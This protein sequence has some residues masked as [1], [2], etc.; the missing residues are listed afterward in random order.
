[1]GPTTEVTRRGVRWSL[2]LRE[3]IDFAIWL[4]GAFEPETVRCYE[5]LIKSGDIVLD[6]GANIGAHTLRLAKAV[7]DSGRVIAFEPT[8]YAFAKLRRNCTLNAELSSRI[9]CMQVMLVSSEIEGQPTPSLYSSWPLKG[10]AD[11]HRLHQ[12]RL[13][14]TDGAAARTL[15]SIIMPMGLQR[16]DYMKL[17]IDGHECKMLRG[18]HRVLA[19]WHPTI[20][21]ELMPYG[22]EEQGASLEELVE[23]LGDLD[24]RFYSLAT[25]KPLSTD[26]SRL[27]ALIPTGASLNVLAIADA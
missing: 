19:E 3:G 22:L 25:R 12:G 9:E 6:V 20:I 27:M 11:T 23:I 15:D 5:G 13:M 4:L 1:M 8:D 21:M 10:E 24:Y 14:F 26:P 17:D 2:D 18:A 16:I 7:S